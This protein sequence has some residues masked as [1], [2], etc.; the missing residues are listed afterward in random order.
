MA[1]TKAGSGGLLESALTRENLQAAWRRVKTNKGAASKSA[2][3][4]AF[5]RKFLGYALWVARAIQLRHWQRPKV[6]YRELKALGAAQGAAKQVAANS[7]RWW[8]NS[9]RLLKTVP[10]IAYFDRLGLPRLS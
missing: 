10:T 5:G 3:C 6:T 7:R 4:S 2:V 8:R 1:K 9:D